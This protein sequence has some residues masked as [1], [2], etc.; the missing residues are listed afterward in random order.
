M[1]L[2]LPSELTEP[3]GWIGLTWPQADEVKL[4]EDGQVW[5]EFGEYVNSL[6]KGTDNVAK[7]VWTTHQGEPFEAFQRFWMADDGPERRLSEDAVGA[8]LT[9]AAL[10]VFA[11]VT[12]AMKI[13]FIVQLIQ[14]IIEVAQAIAS[15]FVSFGAT[16]AE[17]PGFIAATKVI[18]KRLVEQVVKHIQTVIKD[19]LEKAKNLFKKVESKLGRREAEKAAEKAAAKAL[20]RGKLPYLHAGNSTA[21]DLAREFPELGHGINPRFGEGPGFGNNCQSCVVATDRSLA[22]TPTRAVERTVG[23]DPRFDWPGSAYRGTG[24]TSPLRSASG[25]QDIHNELSQ[26]GSG[27]RGIMHGIRNGKPGH[28]FNVVN[29][30][31]QIAYLDGQ[32]GRFAR[33][34]NFDHFQFLRT[35]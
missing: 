32:T 1:G 25:Y 5:I 35:N 2:E 22:G 23:P 34:E 14:L 3:L 15:A 12:L 31:G 17:V 19:L 10:I 6:T 24:T 29:R 4:F 30:N 20:E 27:A 21:E 16:M 33:L 11:G 26:A 9:G 28:V 7:D 8:E 13:A 18:C